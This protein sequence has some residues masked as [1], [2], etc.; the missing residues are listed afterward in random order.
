MIV[1]YVF[2]PTQQ[3]E[4]YLKIYVLMFYL[5]YVYL[6]S[7]VRLEGKLDLQGKPWFSNS[8][9][10][11]SGLFWPILSDQKIIFRSPENKKRDK[12]LSFH[13]K[14][15]TGKITTK[16]IFPWESGLWIYIFGCS[17]IVLYKQQIVHWEFFHIIRV[18]HLLS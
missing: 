13:P 1:Q 5:T 3:A 16:I 7:L 4:T 14:R 10:A 8:K 15:S 6:S 18:S 11:I 12:F 2:L 17:A 9:F